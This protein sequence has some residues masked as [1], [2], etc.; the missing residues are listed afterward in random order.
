MSNDSKKMF[1]LVWKYNIAF[2]YSHHFVFFQKVILNKTVKLGVTYR[3]N[4][5]LK[6]TKVILNLLP[7]C[8]FNLYHNNDNNNNIIKKNNFINLGIKH[9]EMVWF[10]AKYK[11][12]G[13]LLRW[14]YRSHIKSLRWLLWL[15]LNTRATGC[16]I[17]Y[18]FFSGE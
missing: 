10:T 12:H 8:Y 2:S 7:V 18:N 16:K 3:S 15:K 17:F 13:Q 11:Q 14:T 5:V 4:L 1:W 6:N 9:P